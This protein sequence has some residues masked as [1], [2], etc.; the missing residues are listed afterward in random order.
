MTLDRRI[1]PT[2]VDGVM[3]K[4]TCNCLYELVELRRQ[5]VVTTFVIPLQK[6]L[7][8]FRCTFE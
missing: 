7:K 5:V 1:I 8:P 3:L 6:K 4:L 2:F